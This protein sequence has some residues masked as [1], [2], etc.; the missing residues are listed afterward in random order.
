MP[1]VD[2]D[3]SHEGEIPNTP[4]SSVLGDR[5]I[6]RV[7]EAPEPPSVATTIVNE[8]TSITNSTGANLDTSDWWESLIQSIQ[9]ACRDS[10]GHPEDPYTYSGLERLPDSESGVEL[11]SFFLNSDSSASVPFTSFLDDWWTV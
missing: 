10:T 4:P 6:S 11:E 7:D 1:V 8:I 3:F 9:G 5:V 2:Q